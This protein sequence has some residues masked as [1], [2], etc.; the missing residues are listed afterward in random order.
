MSGCHAE[1]E[2]PM[3][4][5]INKIDGHY[6][7][8]E[9]F[10]HARMCGLNENHLIMIMQKLYVHACDLF[11][12][13]YVSVSKDGGKTWSEPMPDDAFVLPSR[14]GVSAVGCDASLLMHKK[15][16]KAVIT[17]CVTHYRNDEPAEEVGNKTFYSVYD[18]EKF[19]P[20]GI[21]DIPPQYQ[22]KSC[23]P[24]SSQFIE[25]EN[26]DLL[27][28]VSI[29]KTEGARAV[30]TVM[31]CSFD[32]TRAVFKEF[33]NTLEFNHARGIYEPSLCKFRGKY[34]LTLRNDDYALFA[35]SGDGIHYSKPDFWRWDTDEILPSD[36]TQQHW[37]A[38][39]DKLYL[40]Y[41]RRAGNNDHVFRHRAPLFMAEVD[42]ENMWI[43]RHTEKIVAP[44]RGARL[45]NFGVCRLSDNHSIIT[46]AEWMQPH[47][48]EKYGS[49]NSIFITDV[50]I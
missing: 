34:Y 3:E 17:G 16:G 27:V 1:T 43:L 47:G 18:G 29:V 24:G 49:N 22:F 26:G 50:I 41:T 32:G 15:S 40:V 6:N 42:T 39:G 37:L 14:G 36:N 4:I 2:V 23:N 46:A 31:R 30:S 21:I 13:L 19:M 45:G 35:V 33:G 11:S 7:G 5:K 28:P 20:I 25:E 10:V 8:K 38:C 48:C 44:E 9:C 12:P